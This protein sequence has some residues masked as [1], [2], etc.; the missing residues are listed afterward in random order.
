MVNK[1]WLVQHIIDHEGGSI[2]AICDTRAKATKKAK[3]YMSNAIA[4]TGPDWEEKR[5]KTET[6]WTNSDHTI[7]VMKWSVT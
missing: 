1:V 5:D 6:E 2:I 4:F 3:E 7:L